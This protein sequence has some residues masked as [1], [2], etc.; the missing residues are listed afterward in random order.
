MLLCEGTMDGHSEGGYSSSEDMAIWPS[1]SED[2]LDIV[3]E[4][5]MDESVDGE[6]VDLPAPSAPHSPIVECAGLSRASWVNSDVLLLND[7]GVVVAEGICR[8]THPH[9]C[10]DQSPLGPDDVGIVILESRVHSEVDPT[11]RFSLRRW[12][13]RNVT[14]DGVSLREHEQRHMQFEREMQSNMRPRKGQ[15]KYDT[16][17][18]PTPSATDCKR[19]RLL[20]EESIREVA[21]KDCC[22]HRCCQLFPRDKLKAI[23]EEMWLG[24]FRLRSTK[25]LDVHRAIHVNGTGRKV[26]T[27]ESIDVCCKAWYTIHGVSKADFYRQAS[28]A[29]EGRRS[30]HHGNV[31][32]KKPRESTR[33]ATATL[34]TIIEPLADAMPH[35]TRTLSTGEKVVEKVLP[36]GTKWKDILLDVNAVGEK[37][38]LQ[39][40][41][42]SKLSAIKKTNFSEY[43][44][45]RRGDKF[46]RCS[47]CE[48][49][50]RL[51]DAHT[52]GT[53][54]YAAH[55][56]NYFKH[57][58]MQ[59]A[60]R[61]DYYTNR[62]LSI[63]RP[64]E[65]LTVI[66]DK[67]DH[68]KTA[69]PCFANRIKATDGFFKLPV[70][71]TGEFRYNI[72][73]DFK[74]CGVFFGD[75]LTIWIHLKRFIYA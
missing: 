22:V 52:M 29:K 14:I 74:Y 13:L 70:S 48:K 41:S 28:Y 68:A 47:N 51:R 17:A 12:P 75:V 60:H 39:P 21:T 69:S 37:V 11:H 19:Q 20:G 36:T 50:K 8:N 63:S 26:I 7:T 73:Y 55:Q 23:R 31:G 24:D 2:D 33:Q 27:I 15:R 58:N 38:G 57:V 64:L 46:A 59:E 71:V 44:T 53:E 65:V 42:L 72:I 56:L 34:A 67:M 43:I 9:D 45:K 35:K 3:G 61:N 49:L 40:I 5:I 16:L 10:I 4:A 30:R 1:S 32:L 6:H 18:R 54:S 62:A 66:H 25:K